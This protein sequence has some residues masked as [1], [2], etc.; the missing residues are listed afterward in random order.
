MCTVRLCLASDIFC[1]SCFVFTAWWT[2][3][4]RSGDPG[5]E[6][7]ALE[8]TLQIADQQFSRW[9]TVSNRNVSQ[10]CMLSPVAYACMLYYRMYGHG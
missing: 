2:C 3:D 9:R 4:K 5:D 7:G 6:E 1:L 8:P 10:T